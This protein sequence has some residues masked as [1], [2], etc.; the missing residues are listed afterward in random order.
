MNGIPQVHLYPSLRV[1]KPQC[2]AIRSDRNVFRAGHG[3]CVSRSK[4]MRISILDQDETKERLTDLD[5]VPVHQ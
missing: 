1:A 3:G 4:G 5:L 2:I